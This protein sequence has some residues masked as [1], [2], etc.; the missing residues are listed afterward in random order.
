M[1][2]I[3]PALPGYFVIDCCDDFSTDDFEVFKSPVIAWRID[4]SDLEHIYPD[5]ICLDPLMRE[6]AILRPDGCVDGGGDVWPNL[7][8]W[9]DDR[10]MCLKEWHTRTSKKGG[11]A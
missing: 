11:A 7:E 4:D 5:A 10:R 3:I 8:A 6:L 2:T 9:A 1:A